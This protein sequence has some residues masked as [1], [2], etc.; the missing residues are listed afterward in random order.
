M[1]SSYQGRMQTPV[2]EEYPNVGEF[3]SR[4]FA[5]IGPEQDVYQAVALIL[6]HKVSGAC[7]VDEE[8]NLMGI[9]SEKDCLRLATQDTYESTPHGGPVREYM[10]TDVVTLTPQCGLGKAA[11]IFLGNPYKKLPVLEGRKL[12]GVVRRNNVLEVIQSF[13]K[14]RMAYMRG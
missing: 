14:K 10:T 3:M 8:H 13:Y 7:V 2:R 9:I 12:V 11:E 1:V 4:S 5:T 6:K